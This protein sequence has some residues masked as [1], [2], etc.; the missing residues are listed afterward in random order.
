MKELGGLRIFDPERYDSIKE[1]KYDIKII[2]DV[3]LD[4]KELIMLKLHPKFAILPRLYKGGLDIEEELA[5]SKLRMQI[6]KE[7]EKQLGLE[8]FTEVSKV[9]KNVEDEEDRI[10]E[11][12]I[13]AKSRQVF[14]PVERVFDERKREVT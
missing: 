12:E 7:L 5:N 2:G 3:E 11:I 6:S 14:D 1:E 4:E 10:R 9:S 8:E 13:E